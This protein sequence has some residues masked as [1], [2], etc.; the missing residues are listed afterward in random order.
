[1][2]VS[3]I[4]RYTERY[5]TRSIEAIERDTDNSRALLAGL[6]RGAG[7][8]PGEFPG[9]WGD[10]F[11]DAALENPEAFAYGSPSAFEWAVYTA[12]TLYAINAQGTNGRK[13]MCGVG[14]GTALAELASV[15][16]KGGSSVED[17]KAKIWKRFCTVMSCFDMRSMSERLRQIVRLMHGTGLGMDY[18]K[19]AGQLYIWQLDGGPQQIKLLW[20]RDFWCT[21]HRQE[22]DVQQEDSAS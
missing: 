12:M 14:I 4:K 1:M 5:V 10:I 18:G 21:D 3:D 15:N 11:K 6:R 19:L 2:K 7:R 17:E 16:A 20:A 22:A 9:L 8:V 13:N